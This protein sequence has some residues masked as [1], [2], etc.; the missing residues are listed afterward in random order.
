MGYGCWKDFGLSINE[1]W[2]DCS[3]SEAA[4]DRGP[5]P[6]KVACDRLSTVAQTI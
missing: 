3:M 2:V 6:R 1:H 5:D 4:E